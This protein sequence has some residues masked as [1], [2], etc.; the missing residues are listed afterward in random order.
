MLK[1]HAVEVSLAVTVEGERAPLD[2]DL[3]SRVSEIWRR[4]QAN[5][6]IPLFDG[7]LLS[8]TSISASR[9]AGQLVPYRWF[10][11]QRADPTLSAALR[12]RPLAVS[13][14]MRCRSGIVFG[15]RSAGSTQDAG[16]WELVPSGGLDRA[17]CRPDGTVAFRAKILDELREETGCPP[18]AVE[19]AE[20]FLL[21][22]DPSS[23]VVDIGIDIALDLDADAVLAFHRGRAS[24]EYQELRVVPIPDIAMFVRQIDT[25]IVEISLALLRT[26]GMLD[27]HVTSEIVTR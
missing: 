16:L 15:R 5:R 2:A 23:G 6:A 3:E 20:P 1:T 22:E 18:G 12:V 11:A 13:G 27:R 14:L 21:V 10:V 25:P 26:R 24:D 4:E 17:S 8:A 19:S 9:I 7:E